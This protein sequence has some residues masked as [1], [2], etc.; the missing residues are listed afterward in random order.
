VVRL[1]VALVAPAF[2]T[3]PLVHALRFL[4][5]PTRLEPGC[6]GCRVWTEENDE[7][8]VQYV[9]EWATEEAIR[10]RVR[11]ERFTR[12]LEVL[13]SAKEAPCVQFDFVMET[14]GLDYVAEVRNSDGT[15]ETP[16]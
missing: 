9:E 8:T 12:L 6:L 1:V 2:G 13:E 11:S 16:P 10:R 5:A 7:P 15:L 4:A 3:K 14:R